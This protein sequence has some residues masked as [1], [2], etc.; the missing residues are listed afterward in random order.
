M[1]DQEMKFRPISFQVDVEVPGDYGLI[2]KGQIAVNDRPVI[3]RS[4]THQIAANGWPYFLQAISLFNMQDGLYRID[5]SLY[6]TQKF[7]KG[8][9][10]MADAAHGSI[11]HGVFKPLEAPVFLAGNQT[12]HVAVQNMTGPRGAP[13][14][15]H[16]IWH[17]LERY[18]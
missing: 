8:N 2:G 6:E 17:G 12:L 15:V 14:T 9:I 4:L 16:I 3:I 18:A 11:R 5:W 10:P 1:A 7:F 13:F